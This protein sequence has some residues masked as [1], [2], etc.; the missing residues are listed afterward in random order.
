MLRRSLLS[1]L[2][3]AP[4]AAIPKA[5]EDGGEGLRIGQWRIYEKDGL[6]CFQKDGDRYIPLMLCSPRDAYVFGDYFEVGKR[7]AFLGG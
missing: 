1:W 5:K 2:G 3:L 6:L 7:D 4:A